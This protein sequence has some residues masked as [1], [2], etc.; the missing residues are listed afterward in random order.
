[1][2][3]S[4]KVVFVAYEAVPFTKVG[5]LCDVAGALPG[6]LARA[7]ADVTL[8]MPRFGDID[9]QKHGQHPEMDSFSQTLRKEISRQ[10]LAWRSVLSMTRPR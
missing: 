6:A 1:M 7:A 8:L 4:P 10:R 9:V 3:S 5:G 2:K